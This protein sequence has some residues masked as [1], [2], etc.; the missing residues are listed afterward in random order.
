MAAILMLKR[1]SDVIIFANYNQ[2][3]VRPNTFIRHDAAEVSCLY[4]QL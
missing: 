2:P 3:I 1:Y 4:I